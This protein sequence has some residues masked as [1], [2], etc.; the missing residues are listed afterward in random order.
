MK[1]PFLMAILSKKKKKTELE[2][3]LFLV[4]MLFLMKINLKKVLNPLFYPFFKSLIK[5][6]FTIP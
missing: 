1:H 4:F 6:F 5:I 3:V 2:R